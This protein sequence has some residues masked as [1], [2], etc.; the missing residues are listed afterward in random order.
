M[1]Y[2]QK[3]IKELK[4]ESLN[5]KIYVL[6]Q[7]YSKYINAR[8]WS[9][10]FFVIFALGAI[11][12]VGNTVIAVLAINSASISIVESYGMVMP[13]YIAYSFIMVVIS[14]LIGWNISRCARLAEDCREKIV[15][16]RADIKE[17]QRT[18]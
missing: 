1:N 14:A 6:E 10:F 4:I 13:S 9:I 15:F 17:I 2:L 8:N 7:S 3:D 12:W 16:I 5:N 11:Y 18:M